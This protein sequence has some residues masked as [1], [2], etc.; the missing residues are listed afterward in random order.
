MTRRQ[1]RL[2]A[3]LTLF[4][5]WLALLALA[6][7]YFMIQPLHWFDASQTQ[8]PA[9]A[10]TT[11]QQQLRNLL[12]EQFPG[13]NPHTPWLVRFRQDDCRCE[14][15]VDPYHVELASQHPPS[16]QTI[17]VDMDSPTLDVTLRHA[18][19]RWVTASPAAAVFDEAG[20]LVYF[21]PYHQDGICS[22]QNSY[23]EPILASLGQP[24]PIAPLLNTLVFGCFCPTFHTNA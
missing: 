10:N 12:R 20:T 17:T 5:V 9:L 16:W 4:I 1:P 6:Y 8:P 15:F 14:R 22:A 23:L 3:T 19:A 11:A 13:L 2:L 7:W 21:G 24:T 18:L